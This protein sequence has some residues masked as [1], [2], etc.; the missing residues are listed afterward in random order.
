M[1]QFKNLQTKILA[2]IGSLVVLII[3]SLT[4]INFYTVRKTLIRDIRENQLLSFMEASQSNIQMVIEKAME[5]SIVL[6]QD[7]L[8]VKWFQ[9]GEKDAALGELAKAKLTSLNKEMGYFTVFAVNN[10]TKNYWA[11][12]GKLLDVISETDPDDS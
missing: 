3:L 6:A 4:I 2:L 1:I 12:G 5:T 7:P 11:E 9:E 8:L 10:I